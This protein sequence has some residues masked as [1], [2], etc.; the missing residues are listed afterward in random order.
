MQLA[1][2]HL[3]LFPTGCV[4]RWAPT[5]VSERCVVESTR[6]L[7][8][9][10]SDASHRVHSYRLKTVFAPRIKHVRFFVQIVTQVEQFDRDCESTKSRQLHL[11]QTLDSKL[12]AS[13]VAALPKSTGVVSCERDAVDSDGDTT[14]GT[15]SE[16]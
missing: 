7:S 3:S 5:Q 12:C 14:Y 8:D 9:S 15:H 2:I 10:L 16:S 11:I 6:E 4:L 13:R 1:A